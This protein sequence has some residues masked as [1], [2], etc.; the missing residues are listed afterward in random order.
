QGDGEVSGLAI[1][2]P[3]E[4]ADLTLTL[5]PDMELKRPIAETPIGTLTLGFG[6]T[7]DEAMAAALDSMLEILGSRLGVDRRD[8]LALAS[9]F[10]DLRITQVVNGVVGVHAVLPADIL[11]GAEPPTS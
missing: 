3:F 7:L 9:V 10:V 4:R 11:R 1:E 5:R 8:A 6:D 2:C